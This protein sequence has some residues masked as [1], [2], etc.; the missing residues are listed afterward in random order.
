MTRLEAR[1]WGRSFQGRLE[2]LRPLRLWAVRAGMEVGL[3]MSPGRCWFWVVIGSSV[4]GILSCRQC[5]LRASSRS[6]EFGITGYCLLADSV[7]V[8]LMTQ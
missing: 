7:D 1:F 3:R 2:V 4:R 5:G 6:G 8:G